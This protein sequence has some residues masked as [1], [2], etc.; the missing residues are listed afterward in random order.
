MPTEKSLKNL[1]KFT[2]EQDHDKC[3]ANGRKG[4]LKSAQ[5]KREKR[6]MNEALER[7]L[8]MKVR[9]G[10]LIDINKA[11]NIEYLKGKNLTVLDALMVNCII[12]GMKGDI[13]AV[14]FIRDTIGQKPCDNVNLNAEIEES[15]PYDELSVEE[16]RALAKLCENDSTE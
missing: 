2:S 11:E 14:E 12:K 15:N 1:K 10:R 9:S 16:L 6:M 4:G 3:V 7:L 13:K 8:S 5:S